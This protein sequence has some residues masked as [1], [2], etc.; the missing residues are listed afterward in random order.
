MR[1]KYGFLPM[2]LLLALPC[3]PLAQCGGGLT[4]KTTGYCL[5]DTLTVVVADSIVKIDWYNSAALDS[6]VWQADQGI[7]G[8]TVAGGNGYGSGT[9]QLKG[10]AGI[11]VDPPGNLYVA[12]VFNDRI[13]KWP[14]GSNFGLTV[15]GGKGSGAA[16]VQLSGP[17]NVY[18]DNHNN[19]FI[20]DCENNRVQK[21]V[22]GDTIG[23][24]VAGGN[25]QG[26]AA[27]QLILPWGVFAD[28]NGFILVSDV[29]GKVREF[30]PGSTSATNGTVVA[31]QGS[32]PT[33]PD[34]GP[35][36]LNS[37]VGIFI[38]AADN[39]YVADQNNSRVQL[40]PPGSSSGITVAGGNGPR[41]S[42][43]QI[44]SPNSIFVDGKG[45]VFVS[46]ATNNRVQEWVPGA[47]S[48]ITVAGGNG[49]GSAPN[50]LHGP[51][52]VYV[53]TTG[54]LY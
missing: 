48:G 18:L 25:G 5:G 51:Q 21:W 40:Y 10:P 15:A 19:L 50:Q 43:N 8:Y 35:A 17:E 47:D 31:G 26:Y 1:S 27:N 12:D 34:S 49:L 28:Q 36:Q 23:T 42:S 37:P 54:A 52:G 7:I 45:N 33:G 16:S 22:L 20:S 53:D 4:L 9:N 14:P 38:D 24:T 11:F 13:Q 46:D 30:P 39:L 44:S 2:L 6:T 3:R 32:N 29:T 41:P